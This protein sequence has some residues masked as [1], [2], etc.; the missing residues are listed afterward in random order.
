MDI[1]ECYAQVVDYCKELE[2]VLAQF[3]GND[4]VKEMRKNH[5]KPVTNVAEKWLKEEVGIPVLMIPLIE[6]ALGFELYEHQRNYILNKGFLK[7]GR[8][9]GKTTAYCVK[10]AL[11]KGEPIDLRKPELYAD[12]TQLNGHT[13]Y[14][15]RFFKNEFLKIRDQLKSVGLDV[16]GIII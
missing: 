13:E 15:K 16:R 3:I 10:L 11:S 12:E 7:G 6:K 5:I 2:N 8:N 14:A 4:V 1:N 9:T